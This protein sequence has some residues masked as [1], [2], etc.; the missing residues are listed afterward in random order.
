M[1][2]CLSRP[3]E[4]VDGLVGGMMVEVMLD[5]RHDIANWQYRAVSFGVSHC[6]VEALNASTEQCDTPKLTLVSA[7]REEL[8]IVNNVKAAVKLSGIEEVPDHSF[9]IH[10]G[11]TA[12]LTSHPQG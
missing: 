7:G 10:R 5:S 6:S 2:Q 11:G 3:S 1:K 12:D 4:V 8:P 9:I